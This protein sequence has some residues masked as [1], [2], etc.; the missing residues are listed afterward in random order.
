VN[1]ASGRSNI[2]GYWSKIEVVNDQAVAAAKSKHEDSSIE[3]CAADSEWI[4]LFNG[5]NLDGWEGSPK[6]WSVKDGCINASGP[7]SYKQYLINDAMG[8]REKGFIALE[9]HDKN[10]KVKFKDIRVKILE[11]IQE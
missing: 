8:F 5:K 4:N 3:Q 11:E 10:V 6:I 2:A 7:T 9:F 1:K